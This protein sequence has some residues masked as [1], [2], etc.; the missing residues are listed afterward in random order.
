MAEDWARPVVHFQIVARDAP[1]QAAFYRAM[2]NWDSG[3]NGRGAFAAGLGGPEP[4]PG[5]HFRQGER[6]AVVL[7]VQVGDIYASTRLAVELGG[8][9]TAEP[10]GSDAGV[11]RAFIED[12]EGNAIGLI[13]Q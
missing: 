5:G 4:G 9:V 2:F 10:F 1:A 11:T 6:P 8:K 7:F 3:D 13:Q 12:P